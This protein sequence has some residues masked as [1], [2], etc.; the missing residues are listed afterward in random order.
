MTTDWIIATTNAG[1]LAEYRELLS[2]APLTLR[3]LDPESFDAPDETGL[4]FVE[5]ALIKARHASALSGSPAIADDS[6]LCVAALDGAPG[7]RSARYAGPEASDSDNVEKLLREL[8]GVDQ[9]NRRAEFHCVI[10]ALTA[11]EDPAPIIATGSWPGWIS[12]SPRGRH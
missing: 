2:D 10:V 11:P 4:S 12:A 6:G 5:N 8:E 7:V 1:K 9:E 3:A